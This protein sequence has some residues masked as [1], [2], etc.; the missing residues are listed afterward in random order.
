MG[1][2]DERA[3]D[4][5]VF[6]A[7]GFTG[8]LAARYLARHAPPPDVRWAVAGRDREKLE[9]VRAE[10]VA[11]DKDCGDVGLVVADVGDPASLADMARQT[12]VVLTTVGPYMRYGEPVVR[13]CVEQGAHYVDI[14]GEPGFVAMTLERYDE[15]ARDR[16][17]RVVSCCGFDS[18]PH[19]LGAFYTV[20]KLPEGVPLEVQGF[21]QARGSFSGG[22]WTSAIEAF[23]RFRDHA[24]TPSS[25]LPGAEGERKVR[26]LRPRVRYEE[27]VQGWVA[28]LPTIDPQVVLRSARAIERYGPD[29]RYAHHVRVGA[30]PMLAGGALA[31]GGMVALSQLEPTRELLLKV[32]RPGEGPGEAQRARNWFRVTFLGRGGGRRVVTQVSGGDPGYD[33]TAKMVSESALCLARDGDRLPDRA[34]VLTPAAAMEH[35]LLERLERAGIRFEVLRDEADGA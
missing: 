11:L 9:R 24:G 16:G 22:T 7:T 18:I 35:A 26:G 21:V 8:R 31:I 13:A 3:Y 10:L 20:G 33:E 12:R 32:R 14:T 23:A 30:L 19:D 29:F 4:V 34:G 2:N 28:P 5:V 25:Q 27:T 6:G 17:V 1:S 15:M